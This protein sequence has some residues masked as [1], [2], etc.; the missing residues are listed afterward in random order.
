VLGGNISGHLET[1]RDHAFASERLATELQQS[2]K[3][4]NDLPSTQKTSRDLR[5]Q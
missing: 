5:G 4:R 2:E 1:I 3:R